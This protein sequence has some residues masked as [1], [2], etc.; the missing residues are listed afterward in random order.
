MPTERKIKI[1]RIIN[2][3]RFLEI[4][5]NACSVSEVAKILKKTKS[6]VKSTA[7]SWRK[8]G[9]ELKI[10]EDKH[11]HNLD[12]YI[13]T[14]EKIKEETEKIRRRWSEESRKN[15]LRFDWRTKP[16]EFQTVDPTIHRKLSSSVG[17]E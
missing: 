5:N 17:N 2:R 4:W 13:P 3:N 12:V 9:Y 15:R 16:V 1:N 14:P 6:S 8:L 10:I 11:N 7:H